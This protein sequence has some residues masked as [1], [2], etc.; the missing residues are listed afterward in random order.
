MFI[1]IVF[2]KIMDFREI[3]RNWG[4][5]IDIIGG[6]VKNIREFY[7]ISKKL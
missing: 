5:G 4:N 2:S 3:D 6:P 1:D 7:L